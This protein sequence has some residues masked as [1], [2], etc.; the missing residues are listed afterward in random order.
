MFSLPGIGLLIVVI[1]TRPQEFV[2]ALAQVPL[3]HLAALAAVIGYVIDVRI[4]RLRPV[5]SPLVPWAL[6]FLAWAGICDLVAGGPLLGKRL[7]EL[8]ILAVLFLLLAG[9]IQRLRAFRW[10][11]GLVMALCVFLSAVGVH[12]QFSPLGCIAVDSIM[13]AEGTPDGRA[14]ETALSCFSGDGDDYRCEKVGMFD[15]FSIEGRVRYRGELH[16]PNEMALLL[17]IGGV[18]LGLAFIFARARDQ[19]WGVAEF[20]AMATVGLSALCI[21]Y[22]QSRGGLL[23]VAIICG[24][25]AVARYGA[26]AALLAAIAAP[27]GMFVTGLALATRNEASAAVS[28]MLRY[29]AWSSGMMMF[30][31]SPLFGVGHRQF[32]EHH[33]MTAHNSYVLTVAELGF[34]GLF[35]FLAL[36]TQA[37]KILFVGYRQLGGIPGAA[38]ARVW[39]LGLLAGGL[40]LAFQIGTLSFAYHSVLWIY[41][42]LVAAWHGA[43]GSH[44]PTFSPRL[45]LA[46]LL[47]IC[48][49][50]VAFVAVLMPVFLRLKGAS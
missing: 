28:T 40:G 3:L 22:T 36:L 24:T 4:G 44:L 34:I 10:I 30:R 32:G 48:A 41:L 19:R 27:I 17:G 2:P 13:T 9:S 31:G 21:L 39:A 26:R 7:T 35:L 45:R 37:V 23:V 42:G 18:A 15:T 38:T 16:D 25:F 46:E 49:V 20:A 50:G 8:V 11:A 14:C 6:A 5:W 1:V 47:I 12:Q 29:E 43:V 33:Y